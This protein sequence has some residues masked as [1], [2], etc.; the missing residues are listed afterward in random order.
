MTNQWKLRLLTLW[1]ILWSLGIASKWATLLTGISV[2]GVKLPLG[3]VPAVGLV[4]GSVVLFR[5]A[6]GAR[7]VATAVMVW[8]SV[9][10]LR[11]HLRNILGSSDFHYT[12]VNI[13]SSL[14]FF[15]ING[16]G[17]L[18]LW[19]NKIGDPYNQGSQ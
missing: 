13:I 3:F 7:L 1:V 4:L 14:I 18:Y 6:K 5:H 11:W 17:L 19:R 9:G 12:L 10:L 8:I 2:G 16:A 15:S